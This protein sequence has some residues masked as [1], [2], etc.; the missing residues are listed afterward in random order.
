MNRLLRIYRN[1]SIGKKMM[2]LFGVQ[3]MIP[4]LFMGILLYR[5][6]EEI[7]NNK[8]INYAMDLIKMIELRINDF[9]KDVKSITL[10]L[11]YEDVLYEVLN[12]KEED[13]YYYYYQKVDSLKS[14]LRRINFAKE[15]IQSVAVIDRDGEFISYNSTSDD[16]FIEEILPYEIVRQ[17]ASEAEGQPIWHVEKDEFGNVKYVFLVRMIYG[18]ADYNEIGILALLIDQEQLQMIYNE[19]STEFMEGIMIFSEERD[20]LISTNPIKDT[21]YINSLFGEIQNKA[22]Y[23]ISKDQEFLYPFLQS[24]ENGWYVITKVSLDTLNSDFAGFQ[25]VLI[26]L[27]LLT[28]L[29]LSVFTLLTAF[30]LLEPIHRL[31][32]GIKNMVD[33]K[34]YEPVHIDRGD[35]LGYL[36]ECFNNMSHEIDFLVNQVYKE[37]LTRKEAELKALQAQINPHFLFNTLESIN[38]LAQLKDAPEISDMV[39]ALSDL[40]EASI[41]KGGPLVTLK[42]ELHHARSYILIMQNRFGERLVYEEVVDET[43]LGILIPKLTLQ[44]LIE[45]AIY[46]GVDKNRKGGRIRICVEKFREDCHVMI[47]DDGKGLSNVRTKEMNREFQA[48]QDDYLVRESKKGIGLINVNHRIKLYCGGKY[49]L[50]IRSWLDHGTKVTLTLPMKMNQGGTSNHV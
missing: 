6:A 47:E 37:Q 20:L 29:I 15:S 3:I 38:W 22:D 2:L 46:H 9:D 36:S 5:N 17:K 41:G 25:L 40:M 23:R 50:K 31:A 48:N 44:P 49:G 26:G 33:N 11:L 39:T 14:R 32:A 30:D 35:E 18:I 1:F 42:E 21:T 43:L 28:L 16:T 27:L 10:D 45:N 8:S 4:I 19:L 34:V 13:D 24:R 7:I 12:S